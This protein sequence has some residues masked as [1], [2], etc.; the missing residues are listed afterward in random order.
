MN[1]SI[2]AAMSIAGYSV[3]TKTLAGWVLGIAILAL[4]WRV[5]SVMRDASND[6][7][8]E[9]RNEKLKM[10]W[11]VLACGIGVVVVLERLALISFADITSSLDSF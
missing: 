6:R 3:S 11:I 2:I 4:A 9:N 1:T 8:S 7:D 10:A 5:I